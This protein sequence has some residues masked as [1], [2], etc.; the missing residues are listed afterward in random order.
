MG[1]AVSEVETEGIIM[2]PER[3]SKRTFPFT[4]KQ[5]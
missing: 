3:K 4:K 5:L 2:L 1:D